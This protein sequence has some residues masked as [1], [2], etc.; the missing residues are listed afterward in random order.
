[1]FE[2]VVDY[3]KDVLNKTGVY[4]LE[5]LVNGKFYIGSTGLSFKERFKQHSWE[6][7]CKRHKNPYLQ[8]AWNLYGKDNFK[9]EIL[10]FCEKDKCGEYEQHLLDEH[11]PKGVLYNINPTSSGVEAFPAEVIKRRAQTLSKRWKEG[12]FVR[13]S[14]AWNKGKVLTDEHKQALR[15]PKNLKPGW[16]EQ[17]KE[18]RR[19]KAKS[20]SVYDHKGNF[21]MTFKNIPELSEFSLT[22]KNNLPMILRC[23]DGRQNISPRYISGQNVRNVCSGKCK[24]YKGLQFRYQD[25]DLP[26]LVLSLE[27][28]ETWKRRPSVKTDG[29]NRAKSVNAEIANAELTVE[30]TKGSTVV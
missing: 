24:H 22:D 16:H 29:E 10:E 12:R 20:V 11:F 17:R 21:L 23:P 6:L 4:K 14:T 19:A 2:F 18:I 25:S 1:M 26:L 27:D 5:N 30:I 13:N 3:D 15:K 9:A 8:N 7:R 28:I